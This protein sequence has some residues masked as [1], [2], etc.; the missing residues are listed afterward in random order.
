VVRP[1]RLHIQMNGIDAG[2]PGSGPAAT[3]RETFASTFGVLT[4]MIGVAV[5]LGAVWRFPYMVGK[6]G[7]AAFV[8]VYLLVVGLVG[9]PALMA[10]WTLGR[11]TRRGTLGAFQRG[12]LPGGKIVG[13]FLFFVVFCAM[14][15]YSNVLG[16]VGLHAVGQLA[17][18][19]GISMDAAAILPPEMGFDVTALVL[20]L[21]MTGLV[22]AGC[23]LVII[24]GLRKGIERV[25]RFIV[26]GL[27]AV[28]LILI[29]RSL[30]LEGS[31]A[32]VAWYIG[33]FRF[34]ELTP[35]VIAA[36]MG[37]A[38]FSMS[39]GGTFMVIYGSYLDETASIPK[40]AIF[41][42]VGASA[43]GLLAG[44]AI[45]PAVFAFGLEPASGPGLIFSTL[46][47]TFAAMP[48]GW[49]FGF[50]F[51]AGLFGAA[52]LSDVAA[53]EVLVGGLVDN[54]RIQRKRAALLACLI[55]FVLAVPPM[56]NL[57]VF[58]P[59]DLLFGSGMQVLG[60][61]LAVITVGWCFTTAKALDEL[62]RGRVRKV[63]PLLIWWIRVVVPIS[64]LA[65]GINWLWDAVLN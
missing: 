3:A 26:P 21:A 28:L 2:E 64:I 25:S 15:Y 62:S 1:S 59:W 45:F 14:G 8:L 18:G 49:F 6:F 12:G 10:E 43:A 56:V 13:G 24:R 46:P 52:F 33:G 65:V 27:F 40:N 63:S 20:Q 19:L 16:W 54:T 22:V 11:E 7:G 61:L 44:F 55:V 42:G 35:S 51:F 39:L 9:I 31:S 29:V 23:G 36:A 30:T 32:G 37:M 60:S 48:A 58:V 38:F 4:T 47:Q 17:S 34:E 41:T 53:L 5:G 57:G 50:L